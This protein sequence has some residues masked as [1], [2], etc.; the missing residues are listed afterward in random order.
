MAS[1][2]FTMRAATYTRTRSRSSTP[3]RQPREHIGT[4]HYQTRIDARREYGADVDAALAEGRIALGQPWPVPGEGL[5]QDAAG[6]W[7]RL[8]Y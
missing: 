2:V 5:Q 7:W 4:H 3:K 1:V 6:R 8:I